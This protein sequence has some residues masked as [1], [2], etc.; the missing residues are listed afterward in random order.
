[1]RETVNIKLAIEYE[2]KNYFGWQRQKT[3]PSVQ[4]AI[5][6]ALRIIFPGEKINLIGSGRTDTGVHALNQ[7]ANF[8]LSG[9]SFDKLKLNKLRYTLNSLLPGDIAVKGARP[10]PPGFHSRYSAK[11]RIY[12]YYLTDRKI[13][14]NGDKF[15]FLKTRFDIDLAKDYCKLLSV[16]HSFRSLCKN[17]ADRRDFMSHVY[18]AKIKKKRNGIY[19]FEICANRFLHSMVRAVVGL[20][21]KVASSKLSLIEFKQKFNNGEPLKIQFVPSNALFLDRVIY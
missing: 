18:Y 14:V 8:K 3:K 4:Q 6:N 9:K 16:T 2:G 19:I 20:M 1:L 21:L 12:K 11:K 7:V 15:Y 5:E 17:K 13:A 10:V